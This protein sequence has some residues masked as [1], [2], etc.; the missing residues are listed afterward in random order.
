MLFSRAWGVATD[1]PFAIASCF[2]LGPKA[3]ASRSGGPSAH[4]RHTER[5]R[6]I[7]C[8]VRIVA[9]APQDA[10]AYLTN[11]WIVVNDQDTARLLDHSPASP[12]APSL[13][14]SPS[15][16]GPAVYG[17]APCLGSA[18][19]GSFTNPCHAF[20]KLLLPRLSIPLLVSLRR[21]LTLH[22]Q[23]GELAPLG[24]AL[25]WHYRLTGRSATSP[26]AEP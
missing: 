6:A 17:P 21:D 2:G 23:L 10:H 18:L 11:G 24:L 7:A 12:L 1:K 15:L 20:G 26:S 14:S 9:G 22:Q 16:S 5:G 25:E 8:F 19:L 4:E 13:P 3:T